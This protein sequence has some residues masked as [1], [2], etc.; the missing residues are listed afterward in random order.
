MSTS[1][2]SSRDEVFARE[3]DADAVRLKSIGTSKEDYIF[4]RRVDEGL[5]VLQPNSYGKSDSDSM[6]DELLGSA[7]DPEAARDS[8]FR[9][10]FAADAMRL[11]RRGVSETDFIL[12]RRIDVG[13][14]SLDQQVTRRRFA[15]QTRDRNH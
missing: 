9:A 12:S 10:E 14:E 7:S 1:T 4:S 3:Y 5:E 11:K 15:R 13:L 8:E 2:E 6:A